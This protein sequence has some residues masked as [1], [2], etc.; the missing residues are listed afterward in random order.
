MDCSDNKE[1]PSFPEGLLHAKPWVK[2]F[3]SVVSVNP[4]DSLWVD[5]L[6]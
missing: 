2:Y 4:H 5:L 6:S 3:M 1:Q